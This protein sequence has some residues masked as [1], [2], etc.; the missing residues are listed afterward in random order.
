MYSIIKEVDKYIKEN[1]IKLDKFTV[2][3]DLFPTFMNQ[4]ILD[5][6]RSI[7]G[8]YFDLGESEYEF[9]YDNDNLFLHVRSNNKRNHLVIYADKSAKLPNLIY[10]YTPRGE[11]SII[12]NMCMQKHLYQGRLAIR[13]MINERYSDM[14]SIDKTKLEYIL[15]RDLIEEEKEK[16]RTNKEHIFDKLDLTSELKDSTKKIINYIEE[17]YVDTEEDNNRMNG[18]SYIMPESDRI[19]S[20][21]NCENTTCSKERVND[22]IDIT[23]RLSILEGYDYIYREYAYNTDNKEADYMAY[24]YRISKDKY[25]LVLEPNNGIKYTKI[26]VIDNENIP[27]KEEFV[28]Y[29][30]YYLELSYVESLAEKTLVRCSH[31]SL[32][33]YKKVIDYSITGI[34]NSF[35]N[36]CLKNRIKGLRG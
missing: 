23:D 22:I 28:D 7:G 20:E 13:N 27:T 33:T 3:Y 36:A 10:R 32:S 4:A 24:L 9:V 31:T 18:V 5:E 6:L 11:D 1:N 16:L 26:A 8:A 34:T 17:T 12:R 21:H 35:E 14:S 15:M 25:I 2:S 29:V 30:R 19:I